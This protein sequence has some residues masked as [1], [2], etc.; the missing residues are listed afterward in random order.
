[1]F[2]FLVGQ[3][4]FTKEKDIDV[5]NKSPFVFVDSIE[6]NLFVEVPGLGSHQTYAVGLIVFGK[7]ML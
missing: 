7:D 2:I 5:T 3:Y 4:E 1:M 6:P